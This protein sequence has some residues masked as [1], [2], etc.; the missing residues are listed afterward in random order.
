[1]LDFQSLEAPRRGTGHKDKLGVISTEVGLKIKAINSMSVQEGRAHGGKEEPS[2]GRG[3]R[4]C[5]H[6]QSKPCAS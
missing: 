6:Q 5:C 3:A 1:M 4:K 2:R